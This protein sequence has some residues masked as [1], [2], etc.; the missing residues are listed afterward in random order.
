MELIRRYTDRPAHRTSETA[1]EQAVKLHAVVFMMLLARCNVLIT[2][3][4]LELSARCLN[5]CTPISAADRMMTT[6]HTH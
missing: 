3:I 1:C 6:M 2:V 5:Y 4:Q